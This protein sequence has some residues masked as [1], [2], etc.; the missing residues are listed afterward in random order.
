MYD[1]RV[2]TFHKLQELDK[3]VDNHP[4]FVSQIIDLD[5]RNQQ[6]HKELAGYN[7]SKKFVGEHPLVAN[8][9]LQKKTSDE[10]QFLKKNFPIKLLSEITNL[11]QNIRRVE[12]NIR[13]KKFHSDDELHSWELNLQR[14][15]LK[16]QVLAE[17][18]SQ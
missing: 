11:Q 7:D 14:L 18:I 16:Q 1:E 6:A 17:I 12:S 5:I 4:E 9:I 8:Y 13:T 10:Y 15:K 2:N 3:M